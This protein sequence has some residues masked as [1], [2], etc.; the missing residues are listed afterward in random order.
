ME[1]LT[2]NA[3]YE[4]SPK[5]KIRFA[6]LRMERIASQRDLPVIVNAAI[7][8][9]PAS[10]LSSTLLLVLDLSQG[11]LER[12]RSI[13]HFVME[14]NLIAEMSDRRRRVTAICRAHRY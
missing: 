12:L 7:P 2:I 5:R 4:R 9:I 8:P 10:H 13:L 11:M 3:H 6:K 14:A 1:T